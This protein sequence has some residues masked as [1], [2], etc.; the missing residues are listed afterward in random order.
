I[1]PAF[2]QYYDEFE[3]INEQDPTLTRYESY[4][5]FQGSLYSPP[6]QNFSSSIGL[7]ISNNLEAKVRD[8]DSTATEPKKVTLLN[9]FNVGT[10]YNLAGDSLRLAPLSVRGSV[11]I[12]QQ[13]LDIN[14]AANLDLYG[15][16]NNN[17]R[18]DRL[19]ISNGG[20]LF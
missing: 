12:I 17:R 11:P 6:G 15:L 14:M 8:K 20:S 10:A 7:S 5:R 9:N 1:N 3:I 19:N 2:D 16:D 18:V 13:K 4:S